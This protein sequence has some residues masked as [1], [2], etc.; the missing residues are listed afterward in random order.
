MPVRSIHEARAMAIQMQKEKYGGGEDMLAMEVEEEERF[1]RGF[2]PDVGSS[3]PVAPL[4]LNN[5]ITAKLST[6]T[7]VQ[8][9]RTDDYDELDVRF[10]S[11]LSSERLADL[12]FLRSLSTPSSARSRRS[13]AFST[14][15]PTTCRWRASTAVAAAKPCASRPYRPLLRQLTPG[16]PQ[17]ELQ[18][19]PC[20]ACGEG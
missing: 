15:R 14:R 11:A 13:S 4:K 6:T 8:A 9:T 17:H 7:V 16:R 5:R 1:L 19:E 2:S 20:K 12:S 3:S 10:R 18:A